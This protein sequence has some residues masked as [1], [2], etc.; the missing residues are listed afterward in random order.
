MAKMSK[1]S[2]RGRMAPP[3]V[4]ADAAGIDI[5]ATQIYVA[6][7]SDRDAEPVRCFESF[8]PDLM[9]LANWLQTCRIRT[10]AM[11]STGV[12]WICRAGRRTSWIASGYSISIRSDYCTPPFGPS[13]AISPAPQAWRFWTRSWAG[14]AARKPWQSSETATLKPLPKRSPSRW[15]AIIG[16]STCSR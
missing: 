16:R 5:G 10:V 9:A 8:T 14:S 3:V 4:Q 2:H 12:F 11:E 1:H 6:L 15:W 13:R 7:P